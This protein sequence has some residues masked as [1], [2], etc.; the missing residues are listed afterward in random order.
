MLPNKSYYLGISLVLALLLGLNANANVITAMQIKTLPEQQYEQFASRIPAVVAD[1][2]NRPISQKIAIAD[3]VIVAPVTYHWSAEEMARRTFPALWT[4]NEHS[5]SVQ[6][7]TDETQSYIIDGLTARG[8]DAPLNSGSLKNA[9]M[10]VD[11]LG[12]EPPYVTSADST[13]ATMLGYTYIS[14]KLKKW[15]GK[16]FS[17]IQ[18]A[19]PAVKT[20]IHVDI[21]SFWVYK[22]HG[23]M[24]SEAVLNYTVSTL[25]TLK[26]CSGGKCAESKILRD[27]PLVA[28]LIIPAEVADEE[29]RR[30]ENNANAVKLASKFYA[31]AVLAIIDNMAIRPDNTRIANAT[32]PVRSEASG[33]K[34]YLQSRMH[35][36]CIDVPGGNFAVGA[37]L[38][39][40]DCYIGHP[41][42]TFE[43]TSSSEIKAG[44]LCVNAI[45][46]TGKNGDKIGLSQCT[47]A[48]NEKWQLQGG[49]IRGINGRCMNISGAGQANGAAVILWDC[50]G[51]APNDRWTVRGPNVGQSGGTAVDAVVYAKEWPVGKTTIQSRMHGKC[52]D[53]PGGNFVAGTALNV[54]GCV[55]NNPNQAFEL[56][57]NHEIKAGG[58]CMNAMGGTG[59]N[60]DKVGLS[61]CTGAANEKWTLHDG[62][63]RAM[64]GRC[65][66]IYGA[67]QAD[68]AAL[69]L[70]DCL[71]GAPNEL[72]VL[73][74][75]ATS[76][77]VDTGG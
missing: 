24:N 39:M 53:V 31:D 64:N 17:T 52:I 29:S 55:S 10:D 62:Q 69:I 4:N 44:G 37:A 72:W 60:G 13:G 61:Q 63:I 76:W 70:W 45:G 48:A 22:G 34:V 11:A 50:Q 42:Q 20:I 40:W 46:G 67:G 56:T 26:I 25:I 2:K 58:L 5:G 19:F 49:Q 43:L 7:L 9:G 32:S 8:Y 38:N 74:E 68:A 35:G 23:Q 73:R 66:N 41:N 1:A 65:V 27:N 3:Q 36:K 16:D 6:W 21:G 28:T 51:G 75:M 30:K 59:K 57:A 47:G 33:S 15:T 18:A 54:W 71:G 14:R 77:V 12:Y